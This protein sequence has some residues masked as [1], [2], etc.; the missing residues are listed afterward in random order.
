M[1]NINERVDQALTKH[2]LALVR[3][4][5]GQIKDVM[6]DINDLQKEIVGLLKEV[7]PRN[8]SQLQGLLDRVDNAIENSY[9]TIAAKSIKSFLELASVESEAVS[10]IAQKAFTVPI[11]PNI[12]PPTVAIEIVES[13]IAPNNPRGIPVKERW[14]RQKEG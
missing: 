3:Y 5:N 1:A 7:E 12:L 6:K 11:A 9:S 4:S 10:S 13:G 8:R 2:D 14:T